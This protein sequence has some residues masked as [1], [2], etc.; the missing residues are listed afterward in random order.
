MQGEDRLIADIR[1]FNRFYTSQLGLLRQHIFDS[2]YSLTESRVLYEIQFNGQTTATGIRDALKI[3]AGYLSR[4]LR[5][6][7]KKGLVL[8]HPLPEDGRSS[9]LQLTA[10]GRKA[11]AGMN[12]QSNEQ[13]RQMLAS[14]TP[15]QREQAGGAMN[16]LRRL[17][18]APGSATTM[19]QVAIRTDLRPGDIGDMI[20]LHG[21]VYAEEY[22]YDLTFE[23]YVAETLQEFLQTYDPAKD[24][25]WLAH[26]GGELAG[27]VAIIHRGKGKGQLR[28]FLLAPFCRGIGLGKELLGQAMAFCRQQ[29]LREVY[30]LTTHQQEAAAIL[31]KKAGFVK[32][33][34]TPQRLWG[35]DLYEERYDLRLTYK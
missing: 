7:E 25:V 32:T 26:V 33:A 6:F 28:W 17:L 9:Y 15:E 3:D 18:H 2:E 8:K 24:R 11:V 30:L 22:Q 21:R 14:L 23:Q 12:E 29:R 31:Y 35:H 13:I 10:R 4:V 16:L 1:Q 27:M 19:D 5:S 34:S 20:R